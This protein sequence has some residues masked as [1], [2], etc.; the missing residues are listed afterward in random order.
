M[1]LNINNIINKTKTMRTEL[2][3]RLIQ[4]TLAFKFEDSGKILDAVLE[5][6]D[7]EELKKQFK[8]VCAMLSEPLVNRLEN[9][10]SILRIS[11]REFIEMSIVES[12]NKADEIMQ[13]FGIDEFI[14]SIAQVQKK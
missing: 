8:N 3:Q 14:E 10:L 2:E 11:K 6:S 4:K 13:E 7:H 9:T 1:T 12:L 5:S